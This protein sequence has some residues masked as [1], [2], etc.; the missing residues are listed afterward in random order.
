MDI[1][2]YTS[3]CFKGKRLLWPLFWLWFIGV[4]C[5]LVG[6]I[7]FFGAVAL[8]SNVFLDEWLKWV[9]LL[10]IIYVVWVLVSLWRCAFNVKWNGWGY[11][12][13]VVVLVMGS[14]GILAVLSSFL[15]SVG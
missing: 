9:L 5:V 8:R 15:I 10:L 11:L 6:I 1:A 7:L 12:T 14:I 13:R 2:K 3:E 4:W